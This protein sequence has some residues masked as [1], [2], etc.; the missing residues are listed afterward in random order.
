MSIL[1]DS[2][3]L[4]RALKPIILDIIKHDS[5]FK[6]CFRVYKATVVSVPSTVLGVTGC[7]VKIA[8]D[9]NTM[10]LP[11][12]PDVADVSVGD[13]VWVAVIFNSWRNAIVWQKIDFS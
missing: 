5:D 1:D 13:A 4:K 9:E 10:W 8:G 11:Y 7:L 2:D 12:T 6:S 3:Q